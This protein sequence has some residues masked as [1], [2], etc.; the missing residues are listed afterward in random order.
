M[1]KY[2]CRHFWFICVAKIY[3]YM[4][5]VCVFISW[6]YSNVYSQAEQAAYNNKTEEEANCCRN[7]MEGGGAAGYIWR[8]QSQPLFTQ[9]GQAKT[10]QNILNILIAENVQSPSLPLL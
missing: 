10:K 7:I 4:L 6:L 9:H 2:F 5:A 1:S 8:N 3:L